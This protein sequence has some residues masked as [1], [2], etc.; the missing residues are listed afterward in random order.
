MNFVEPIALNRESGGVEG[1]AVLSTSIR[2]APKHR[3]SLC[4]P[5]KTTS[6]LSWREIQRQIATG[7]S[8]VTA[9]RAYHD[10]FSEGRQ[11]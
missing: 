2:F 6:A 11:N 8:L 10:V 3:S 4:H 1:S 5:T 9:R 7:D